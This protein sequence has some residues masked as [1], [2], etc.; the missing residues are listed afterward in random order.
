MKILNKYVLLYQESKSQDVFR[1]IYSMVSAEWSRKISNVAQRTL[2]DRHEVVAAYEDTLLRT[3]SEYSG[4][5]DYINFLR[6]SLKNAETDLYR[7]NKRRYEML[8]LIEGYAVQDINSHLS[9]DYDLEKEIIERK[10]EADKRQLIDFLLVKHKDC[11]PH[12]SD[13]TAIVTEILLD[14]SLSPSVNFRKIAKSLGMYD[15]KVYRK[16]RGLAAYYDTNQFGGYHD[17]LAV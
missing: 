13:T 14:K 3:L 10:K 8:N 1:W 9:D 5:G 7:K 17:Y 4:K 11:Q 6:N 12:D 15:R 16:L 2:S